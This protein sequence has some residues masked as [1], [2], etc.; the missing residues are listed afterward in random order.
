MRLPIRNNTAFYIPLVVVY[1]LRRKRVT[2]FEIFFNVPKIPN[3]ISKLFSDR[4]TNLFHSRLL[5][6]CLAYIDFMR[7]Y[8][9]SYLIFLGEPQLQVFFSCNLPV[10]PWLFSRMIFFVEEVYHLFQFLPRL[11]QQG[12]VH[13]KSYI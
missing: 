2:L 10:C 12:I 13:R 9:S 6:L 7:F 11:I 5:G 4:C 8:C 3:H 1:K